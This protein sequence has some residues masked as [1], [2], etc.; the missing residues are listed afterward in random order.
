M[1]AVEYDDRPRCAGCMGPIEGPA[2]RDRSGLPRHVSCGGVVRT[3]GHCGEPI[4]RCTERHA[5]WDLCLGWRLATGDLALFH[6]VVCGDGG[7]DGES[8][9]VHEPTR[10]A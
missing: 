5:P 9:L 6:S 10:V 4:V 7:D 8:Y 1:N 3:C 2:P